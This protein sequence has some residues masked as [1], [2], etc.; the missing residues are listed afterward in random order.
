MET[1]HEVAVVALFISERGEATAERY[2]LHRHV[3]SRTGASAYQQYSDRLGVK[4]L[5]DGVLEDIEQAYAAVISRFGESFGSQY[6]WAAE[7]L[8]VRRPTFATDRA[9]CGC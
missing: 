4:P 8:Q 6:G 1:L 5:S 2:A 3:E 9:S 7:D